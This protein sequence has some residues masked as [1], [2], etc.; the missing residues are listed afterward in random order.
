MIEFILVIAV[1]LWLFCGAG[2]AKGW[3]KICVLVFVLGIIAVLVL[4]GAA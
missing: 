1:L 3:L 4:A 2:A